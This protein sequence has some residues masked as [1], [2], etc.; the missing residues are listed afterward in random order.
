MNTM[1]K[2]ALFIVMASFLTYGSC[3]QHEASTPEESKEAGSEAAHEELPDTVVELTADQI[4]VA[5][6]EYGNIEERPL[7]SK[8]KASGVI[9]APP[10][11]MASVCAPMGGFVRNTRLLP[12]SAVR[13]GEVLATIEN[14]EFIDMQQNFLEASSKLEFA[15]ADFKRH[16]QLHSDDVYSTQNLQ[17]VAADYKSLKAQ[18]SALSQKLRLIGINPEALN[19]ANITGS[20]QVLSPINGY[21]RTINASNG[22]YTSPSDVLFEIVNNDHMY[23]ELTL[24]ERDMNMVNPGQQVE[25]FLNNEAENHHAVVYQVAKAVAAD[26]SFKIYANVELPCRNILPGMYVNAEILSSGTRVTSVPSEAV[27]RFNDKDY[28]FIHYR[29]KQENGKPVTE[30]RMV[31]VQKGVSAGKFTGIILPGGMDRNVKVVVKG[32]FQLMAAK[33]NAGEMSC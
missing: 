27:V 23:L 18:V 7:G 16:N 2:L 30:Y 9:M 15:E 8:I 6:I 11:N 4:K 13:K 31:E 10:S 17:Q 22:K 19:E 32:A 12:G 3:R 20:I 28:I 29:E 25:F 5:G 21:I 24:F 33:K 1:N 26:K 14:S